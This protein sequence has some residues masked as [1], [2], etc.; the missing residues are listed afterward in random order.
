MAPKQQAPQATGSRRKAV[1]KNPRGKAAAM[2]VDDFQGETL[3]VS[4]PCAAAWAFF[5]NDACR[6]LV[7]IFSE[8]VIEAT[9]GKTIATILRD[10][11]PSFQAFRHKD[12]LLQFEH[13][14][15]LYTVSR[16]AQFAIDAFPKYV[17]AD[18]FADLVNVYTSKVKE[19]TNSLSVTPVDF[20]IPRVV[21]PTLGS[22]FTASDDDM[23]D[24][25]SVLDVENESLAG[26]HDEYEEEEVAPPPKKMRHELA[27]LH[28]SPPPA[29][30]SPSK[31]RS[32]SS[33]SKAQ[34]VVSTSKGL[35]P[36]VDVPT[37]DFKQKCDPPLSSYQPQPLPP[38]IPAPAAAVAPETPHTLRVDMLHKMMSNPPGDWVRGNTQ[39]LPA[40]QLVPTSF[41]QDGLV[42]ALYAQVPFKCHTCINL[43]KRCHFRRMNTS[44]EECHT[45]KHSCSIVANP[46]RFLQNI[47][48]LRPMMNLGPEGASFVGTLAL[49]EVALRFS[50]INDVL[51]QD[52]VRFFFENPADV[53]LLEGL[54][55]HIRTSRPHPT[56]PGDNT[57]TNEYYVPEEPLLMTDV[58]SST[59]ISTIASHSATIF[60]GQSYAEPSATEDRPG[61]P[62]PPPAV[63]PA[64]LS[65]PHAAPETYVVNTLSLVPSNASSSTS[66]NTSVV[67]PAPVPTTTSFHSVS[68]TRPFG[69]PG[70]LLHYPSEYGSVNPRGGHPL[71]Q[72][73]AAVDPPSSPGPG[74]SSGPSGAA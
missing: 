14:S 17:K 9:P 65:Q 20:I 71:R 44:C 31:T 68:G 47:E 28:S 27:D 7:T 23:E 57:N 41:V 50:N 12:P 40:T 26:D 2:P 48:E 58:P 15:F 21:S 70:T 8:D 3:N 11:L 45:G 53:Q 42:P 67:G 73:A 34:P 6:R 54:S 1:P 19:R 62:H 60:A 52:Y 13:V 38:P 51:P 56:N 74:G 36:F 49:D 32:S 24:A 72:V 10:V 22:G 30:A 66:T 64:A 61:L 37:P 55:E 18:E 43:K 5:D 35:I 63:V 69:A 4:D 59:D 33:P 16:T 25:P 29:L 46:T 39:P